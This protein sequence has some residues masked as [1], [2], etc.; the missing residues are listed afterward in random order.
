MLNCE[1]KFGGR[2]IC[3]ESSQWNVVLRL[4]IFYLLFQIAPAVIPPWLN[5]QAHW[6]ACGNHAA[7][8]KPAVRWEDFQH[9]SY[10]ESRYL[11]F[12]VCPHSLAEK[13]DEVWISVTSISKLHSQF[14]KLLLLWPLDKA[15]SFA[16]WLW[17]VSEAPKIAAWQRHKFGSWKA[18]FT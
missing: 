11:L 15:F 1:K 17:Y 3:R 9:R 7:K 5:Q 6:H 16:Y 12:I 4:H 18:L 14:G 8:E 2:G 13:P 10:I